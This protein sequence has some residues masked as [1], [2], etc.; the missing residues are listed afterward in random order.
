MFKLLILLLISQSVFSAGEG[1]GKITFENR[2][3]N[4]D[5]NRN[6]NDQNNGVFLDFQHK[7]IYRGWMAQ[8][9]VVSRTDSKDSGRDYID[10]NEAYAGYEGESFSFYAGSMIQNWSALEVFHPVDIFNSVNLDADFENR[11]KL[12]QPALNFNFLFGNNQISLFY[13]PLFVAPRLPLGKT[14]L[15]FIPSSIQD[16][17]KD[18]ILVRG[19][20]YREERT[21]TQFIAKADF[22]FDAFDSSFYYLHIY[23]RSNISLATTSNPVNLQPR[24]VYIMTD[25]FGVTLQIPF[26]DFI[27]KYEGLYKKY[28][29]NSEFGDYKFEAF[30]GLIEGPD[31]HL[32]N[33]FG[34]EYNYSFDFGHAITLLGEFQKIQSDSVDDV[35]V[36][37]FFQ[38]DVFVALRWAF[39][40]INTSEIFLS[41]LKDLD[42]DENIFSATYSQRLTDLWYLKSSVRTIRA[43]E[44]DNIGLSNLDN[45]QEYKVNIERR[46]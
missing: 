23:D 37:G 42:R 14:R 18:P 12:G 4:N 5:D 32:I 15:N 35:N 26:Y 38:N 2:F 30:P 28:D 21:T 34:L 17:L 11:E 39:N 10:V 33:S 6:T 43:K 1:S 41:Y 36:L 19:S 20:E 25:Q 27:A 3:F 13:L 40:N 16:Q 44:N 24:P 45:L 9:K 7:M 8:G 46:F 22:S 31:N 29:V